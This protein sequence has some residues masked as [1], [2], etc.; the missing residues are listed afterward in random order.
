MGRSL[1]KALYNHD[2]LCISGD[3]AVDLRV[4][5]DDN[6]LV[7]ENRGNPI[8][9]V[10]LHDFLSSPVHVLREF[11]SKSDRHGFFR[12]FTLL[13][14]LTGFPLTL[15]AIF[16][17]LFCAVLRARFDFRAS[18]V[19][20]SGL[21]LFMGITLLVPVHLGRSQQIGA[22]E[23]A[24]ALESGRWQERVAALK[25]I[26]QERL[27]LGN[28][29][30]YQRVLASPHVAERYWL[31][32]ALGVSRKSETYKDLLTF[33]DDPCPSVVSMAFYALG[34]RGDKRAIQEIVKRIEVSDHWYNQWYAYKALRDLGWRQ[35]GSTKRL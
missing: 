3:E 25:M 18:S 21:C 8:L 17:A 13:S 30:A 6:V 2:Y 29:Q 33:L 23:L 35:K 32:R 16:H 14:L 7:F 5:Q 1:E 11:S 15:Y 9:R 28:F 19:T 22:K 12:Q 4:I 24:G 20:A 10:A 26:E 31:A 34:Q 27:E